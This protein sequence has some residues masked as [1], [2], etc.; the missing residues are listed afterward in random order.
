MNAD[1]K[2]AALESGLESI[3][4]GQLLKGWGLACRLCR[5]VLPLVGT[6]LYAFASKMWQR[7]VK[8]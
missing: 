2:S 1:G 7:R 5:P 4:S 6:Q 3:P 8:Q